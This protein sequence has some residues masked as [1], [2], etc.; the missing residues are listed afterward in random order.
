MKKILILAV[1]FV[2]VAP[3]L[4]AQ[5]D[6]ALKKFQ[7]GFS[8]GLA[9]KFLDTDF[10]NYL[11][12]PGIGAGF[13]GGV[14]FNYHFN[15]RIAL[16]SGVIFDFESFRTQYLVDSEEGEFGPYYLFEDKDI[17]KFEDVTD[18][19]EMFA[20]TERKNSLNYLSI[21]VM[22][23]LQ[24]NKIGFLRYYGKLGARLDFLVQRRV[25]DQGFGVD[26][27][28]PFILD[29]LSL[30]GSSMELTDMNS[31]GHFARIRA[32]INFAVGAEWFFSG[33]TALFAELEYNYGFTNIYR[34][35]SRSLYYFNDES[36]RTPLDIR[37][38]M[39]QFLIK[40]GITF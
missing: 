35:E 15:D 16:S 18:P 13:N 34:S 25:S 38:D 19:D 1:C 30:Q 24:T 11:D 5:E 21:P 23:R 7:F 8:T 32:A 29:S 27:T 26:Y 28:D 39:H 36:Q 10:T 33:N 2:L 20:V 14:V 37:G 12:K 6:D 22:I 40:V 9:L 3:Q 17:D 31:S 4:K